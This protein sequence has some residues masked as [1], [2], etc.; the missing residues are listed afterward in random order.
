[1]K[2]I[3]F[4]VLKILS[5][6]LRPLRHGI[7]MKI[8]Q[9]SYEIQGVKFLGKATY[10]HHDA[11]IDNVGK[12]VLGDKIVVSTRAILLAHDYSYRITENIPNAIVKEKKHIS[13]LIIGNNVFIGAGAIILSGSRIGDNCIIGAGAVVKG[14]IPPYSI[15]VGNPGKVIK[16]VELQ[17]E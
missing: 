12:V 11:Y 16:R 13:D 15:V 1:M 5:F 17:N 8:L 14:S 7:Y 3:A 9:K 4:Y 2:R 10:I 6:F